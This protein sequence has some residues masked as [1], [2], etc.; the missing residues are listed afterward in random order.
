M[1]SNP[2]IRVFSAFDSS[3]YQLS[4]TNGEWWDKHRKFLK[5]KDC[6]CKTGQCQDAHGRPIVNKATVGGHVINYPDK[7]KVYIV[8]MCSSCNNRTDLR[9]F[10]VSK[11]YACE[12]TNEISSSGKPVRE[13]L[14]KPKNLSFNQ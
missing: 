2:I 3:D 10:E 11:I 4:P 9:P 5:L 14:T 8:P 13:L 6:D 7:D 12:C 1:G